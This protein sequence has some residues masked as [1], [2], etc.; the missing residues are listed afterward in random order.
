MDTSQ[1]REFR[2]TGPALERKILSLN[3]KTKTKNYPRKRT[4]V[5][6]HRPRLAAQK[7]GSCPFQGNSLSFDTL[8]EKLPPEFFL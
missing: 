6:R 3:L 2:A 7:K 5:N 1:S 8:L 4:G